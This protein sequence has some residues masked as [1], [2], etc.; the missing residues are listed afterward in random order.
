MTKFRDWNAVS[1]HFRTSAGPMRDSR[2]RRKNNR[3]TSNALLDEYSD[4]IYLCDFCGDESTSVTRIVLDTGYDRTNA[5]A[6]YACREC[7]S[8][9]ERDRLNGKGN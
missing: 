1:A 7:S 5:E 4:T 8:E 9:K 6:K 2:Q 3:P